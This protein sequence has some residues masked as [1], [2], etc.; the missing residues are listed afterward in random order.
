MDFRSSGEFE[1]EPPRLRGTLSGCAW[2]SPCARRL[3]SSASAPISPSPHTENL[4]S[5]SGSGSPFAICFRI[6]AGGFV[7]GFCCA[8]CFA[9][10][11]CSIKN[12]NS[13]SC[14][15]AHLFPFGDLATSIPAAG[16]L[17]LASQ[18]FW[19]RISTPLGVYGA[20]GWLILVLWLARGPTSGCIGVF[21]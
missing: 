12:I 2:M 9:S 19:W 1:H 3:L 7:V 4:T 10:P 14:A 21:F 20:R 8:P 5:G 11:F 6:L 16:P 17:L 13:D 18:N 15:L